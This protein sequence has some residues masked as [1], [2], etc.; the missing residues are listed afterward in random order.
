VAHR[1]REREAPRVEPGA[2]V[3]ESVA[4]AEV[5]AG[6]ADE[7]A[8]LRRLAHGHAAV[9]RLGIL[10]DDDRVGAG[11]DRGAG[12]DPDR[13][14]GA[15]RAGKA[16]AGRARPDQPQDG[17]HCRDVLVAD[18]V[19]VHRGG[20][21]GRLVAERREVLRERAA[22]AGGDRPALGCDGPLDAGEHPGERL[23]DRDQAH[24]GLI[25]GSPHPEGPAHPLPSC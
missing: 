8:G 12:E 21:E 13:L 4:A 24:R 9:R 16:V 14:A 6:R 15:D 3:Q 19:A 20:R 2:G 7:A 17:G 23:V 18:R 11:R 5:E 22:G 10:L 1:G 25:P